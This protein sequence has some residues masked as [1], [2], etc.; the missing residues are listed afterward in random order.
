MVEGSV[1]LEDALK[2]RQGDVR[3]GGQ[4]LED[5]GVVLSPHWKGRRGLRE[6]DSPFGPTERPLDARVSH[7]K[8]LAVGEN[9]QAAGFPV[10]VQ[11]IAIGESHVV[12]RGRGLATSLRWKALGRLGK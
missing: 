2:A 9:T 4:V 7:S 12:F 5:G 1:V 10:L 3:V 11:L 8:V 6:A